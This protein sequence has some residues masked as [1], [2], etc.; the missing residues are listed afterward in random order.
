MQQDGIQHVGQ[1]NLQLATA[2]P[3]VHLRESKTVEAF[4][5]YQVFF[6]SVLHSVKK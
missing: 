4:L 5:N 6:Q 1:I 3:K 2:M